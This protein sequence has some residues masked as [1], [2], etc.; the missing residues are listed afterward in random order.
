MPP[1]LLDRIAAHVDGDSIRYLT[2]AAPY[3][4]YISSAMF[5]VMQLVEE[6]DQYLGSSYYWPGLKL[7]DIGIDTPPPGGGNLYPH[8]HLNAIESYSRI[9]SKHGG[10]AEVIAKEG[11]GIMVYFLP[12]MLELTVWRAEWKQLANMLI[13]IREF[14]R[15]ICALNYLRARGDEAPPDE[16]TN[17]LGSVRI[18]TFVAWMPLPFEIQRVCHRIPNLTTLELVSPDDCTGIILAECQNLK[19]VRFLG[20]F[21]TEGQVDCFME[22]L[23]ESRVRKVGVVKSAI[24]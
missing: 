1:E 12:K 11:M 8:S 9:L 15:S 20:P 7:D 18:N 22:N 14:K 3:F 13:G 5:G 2:H 4:K 21:Q 6:D 10:Y 19:E 17:L 23:K 16:S 24:F